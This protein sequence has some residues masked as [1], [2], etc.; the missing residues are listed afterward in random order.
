MNKLFLTALF[1]LSAAAFA[2]ATTPAATL[3]PSAKALADACRLGYEYG[4]SE[5][6][7]NLY[8]NMLSSAEREGIPQMVIFGSVQATVYSH[9]GHEARQGRAMPSSSGSVPIVVVVNVYGTAPEG[10]EGWTAA[11]ELRGAGGEVLGRLSPTRQDSYPTTVTASGRTQRV[12]SRTFSFASQTYSAKQRALIG[13]A[14]TMW[15]IVNRGQGEEAF[16]VGG[17]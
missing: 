3:Y 17:N 11:L 12:D 7:S 4:R 10:V 15:V 1:A 5:N 13:Q 6:P 9:C 2:Q 16:R 8:E 14:R